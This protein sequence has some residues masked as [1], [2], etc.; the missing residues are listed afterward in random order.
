M[1]GTFLF[2]FFDTMTFKD[3]TNKW[4]GTNRSLTV[5]TAF[6]D[7][8]QFSK[9]SITNTRSPETYRSW[10]KIYQHLKN[11]LIIY[12]D[13]Y[14]FKDFFTDLRKNSSSITEV[15]LIN[16][17]ALWSFKIKPRIAEIYA[18]PGYPKFYPNTVE[19][20]YTS[21]THS[22]L[23]FVAKAITSKLFPSDYYCWIDLGY[24]RDLSDRATNFYL[25]IPSDLDRRRVGVTQVL[26]VDLH[27]IT[28]RSI[29]LG[30]LNWI[31]GG[32]FL[33][34]PD[35]LLKFEKQYKHRV[36]YYLSQ[37]LMNVEQHVLYSM[38]TKSER[39]KNP[40][41]V[42]VQTYIPGTKPAACVDPWFYLGCLMYHEVNET[43]R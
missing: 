3:Y 20:D 24:F 37:G 27:N 25:E 40:I 6:L 30:N 9:G 32:L 12:T 19:P 5:V 13:S 22:K 42:E 41:S 36:M 8:G 2:P 14:K 15:I 31:G 21:M 18:Q 43:A 23:S 11:P 17:K 4:K 39:K 29:I 28:A 38:F 34:K 10:M 33:G 16:R 26:N 1:F 35:I 7:L